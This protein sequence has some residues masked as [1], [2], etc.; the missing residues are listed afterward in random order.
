MIMPLPGFGSKHDYTKNMN[1]TLE[2]I[3]K[4]WKE[5]NI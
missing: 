4:L 3:G 5:K 1:G 2:F